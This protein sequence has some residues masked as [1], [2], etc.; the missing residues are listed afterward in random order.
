MLVSNPSEE[1]KQANEIYDG[2]RFGST[3]LQMISRISDTPQDINNLNVPMGFS[4]DLVELI[5]NCIKNDTKVRLNDDGIIY[6]NFLK[7]KDRCMRLH[8]CIVKSEEKL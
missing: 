4:Q 2:F 1:I 3:L 6:H 5:D 8:E 7:G